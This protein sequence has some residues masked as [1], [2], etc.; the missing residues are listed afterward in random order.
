MQAAASSQKKQESELSIQ[1]VMTDL[2]VKA[3]EQT[4]VIS[5]LKQDLEK[6][7]NESKRA[8]D[9]VAE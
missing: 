5:Q 3:N 8:Q 7:R 2:S 4:Q 6:V 1:Q 9:D